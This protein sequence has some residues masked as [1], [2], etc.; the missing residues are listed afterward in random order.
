MLFRVLGRRLQSSFYLRLCDKWRRPEDGGSISLLMIGKS[1]FPGW[2]EYGKDLYPRVDVKVITDLVSPRR[3]V[4]DTCRR[5][6]AG[7][8]VYDTGYHDVSSDFLM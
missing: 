8:G 6:P 4:S 3:G 1:W 2:N 7:S 5:F